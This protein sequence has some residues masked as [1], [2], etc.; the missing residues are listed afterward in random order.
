MHDVA[1]IGLGPVG[2]TLARLLRQE[3]LDVLA[4]ER[5]A[6]IYPLPRAV[7]FDAEAMRVFQGLGL[8]DAILPLTHVSPGMRFVAPDGALL[9]DWPRPTGIGPL[10]WHASYRFHQPELEA[11]LRDGLAWEQAEVTGIEEGAAGVVLHTPAGPRR[12]RFAVGCDGA[13]SPTRAAIGGGTE[14]LGFAE[15]W[16]VVDLLLSRPAPH[17]PDHSIQF[18]DPRRPATYVRGT[19]A[20]RRFEIRLEEGEAP[21]DPWPLLARWL[22]PADAVLERQ[23]IY[24]FRSVVARRWRAGRLLIA[25]DAAHLTPPFLGQGLCA[26]IRD[27]AN[28][29]WRLGRVLRGA[30]PDALLDAYGAERAPHV[31]EFIATAVRLGGLINTRAMA[32]ALAGAPE[33]GP[34]LMATPAP[35]L[36]G[37]APPLGVPAPQP[38]LA[39]GRR[40]DDH[41]GPRFAAWLHGGRDVAPAVLDALAARGCVLVQDPAL[42]AI[43]DGHGAAC[44]LVRPDRILCALGDDPAALLDHL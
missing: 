41:V 22:T 26:G 36:G 3:G 2:A 6:A 42:D 1:V 8:A 17:L 25:G 7:H 16:L 14:D 11:V 34:A 33:E 18:C 37:F 27:A 40:H 9:L 12:A 39:N 15:R 43:L 28:L 32:A 5:E 38:V 10:G 13:N 29:A 35:R 23:A 30:A 21:T 4:L 19:G 20:R 24:T 31:R 44:A